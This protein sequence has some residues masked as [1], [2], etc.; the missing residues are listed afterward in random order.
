MDETGLRYEI[1]PGNTQV[2][3]DVVEHIARGDVDGSSFTFTIPAGGDKWTRTTDEE[4]RVLEVRELLDVDLFDVSPVVFPAYE[5]TSVS[6]RSASDIS[7]LRA[8]RNAERRSLESQRLV[9]EAELA[10][11]EIES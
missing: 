3:R 9:V 10:E 6:M 4:G 5:G 1:D 8:K 7:D 11:R 2:G